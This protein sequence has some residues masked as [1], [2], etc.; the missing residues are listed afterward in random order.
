MRNPFF[1]TIQTYIYPVSSKFTEIYSDLSRNSIR[2]KEKNKH[3]RISKWT[4]LI[5]KS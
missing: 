1:L 2:I 5:L 4:V 3:V